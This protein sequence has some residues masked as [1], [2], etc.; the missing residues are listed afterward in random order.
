MPDLNSVLASVPFV[1][2]GGVATSLYMPAR[3]TDDVDILI[4]ASDRPRVE[5]AL[6][7]SGAHRVGPLIVGGTAWTLP[8]GT[9]LDVLVSEEPWVRDALA[10]PNRDPSGVPIISLPYLALL[11]LRAG[12]GIDVADLSR[13]L[14]GADELLLDSVRRVV[15]EHE[16]DALED[17]ESLIRLGRMEFQSGA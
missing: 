6:R 7:S 10:T 12:R 3:Q 2:V 17:L 5:Q 16:P 15:A 11:K 9:E 1:V 13:M 14:G 4:W 8:D